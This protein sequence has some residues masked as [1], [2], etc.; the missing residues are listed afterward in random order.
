MGSEVTFVGLGVCLM[1]LV[2]SMAFTSFVV[3]WHIVRVQWAHHKRMRK[4]RRAAKWSIINNAK[5]NR[6]LHLIEQDRIFMQN[7][8]KAISDEHQ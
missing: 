1:L 4:V 8:R 6:R 5:D 7:L 2:L 3:G